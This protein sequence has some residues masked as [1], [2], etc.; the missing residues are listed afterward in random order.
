MPDQIKEVSHIDLAEVAGDAMKRLRAQLPPDTQAIIVLGDDYGFCHVSHT[1]EDREP[2][3]LADRLVDLADYFYDQSDPCDCPEC[4]PD[5][6]PS[7][8]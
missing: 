3:F 1:F 4:S 6:E 2:D 5:D 7:S 8:N